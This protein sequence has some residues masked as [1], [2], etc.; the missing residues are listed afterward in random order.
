MRLVV[1]WLRPPSRK[2]NQFKLLPCVQTALDAQNACESVRVVMHSVQA[3]DYKVH[4]KLDDG[5]PP[6]G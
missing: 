3:P 2:I 4:A 5:L 1:E 6:M